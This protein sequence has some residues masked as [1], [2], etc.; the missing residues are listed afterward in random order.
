MT[1]QKIVSV[2][3]ESDGKTEAGVGVEQTD[4][5]GIAI[6]NFWSSTDTD[7]VYIKPE[8]VPELQK[9]LAEVLNER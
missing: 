1:D 8:D 2:P 3:S 9:A 5:H 4:L 6:T 7:S